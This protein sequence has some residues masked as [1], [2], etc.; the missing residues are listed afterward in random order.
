MHTADNITASPSLKF[1]LS[2]HWL[3]YNVYC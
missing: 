2:C 1:D 3:V